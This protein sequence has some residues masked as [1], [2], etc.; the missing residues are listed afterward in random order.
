MKTIALSLT[1]GG[2]GKTTSSL[3]LFEGLN[4]RG[5]KTL[6]VDLDNQ[7]NASKVMQANTELPTVLDV[8]KDPN[9]V[10]DAIQEVEFGSMIQGDS[11][12][13]L[14]DLAL[15]GSNKL[16]RLRQALELIKNDFDFV[17]LDPSP[18]LGTSTVNVLNAADY[19]LIPA[20]ADYFSLDAITDLNRYID[21]IRNSANPD[22]KIL[23]IFLTMY[24]KRSKLTKECE[25]YAG[26]M[27]QIIGTKLLDTKIRHT[28]K[29]REALRNG[30]PI[31]QY[32]KRNNAALD[33]E[34]LT[35]ELLKEIGLDE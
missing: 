35:D 34:A 30:K 28:V 19:I 24:D 8:L 3:S 14:I 16:I 32:D 22:L 7:R 4:R 23:G 2:V 6:L 9:K 33:Y 21:M 15:D 29:A 27:A 1:K 5:Y 13:A 18:S 31:Y 10:K 25:D 20:I 11:D 17:I 12:L 26:Q